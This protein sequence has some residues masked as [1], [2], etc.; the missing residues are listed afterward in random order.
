MNPMVFLI[1][2]CAVLLLGLLHVFFGYKLAR[3]LLPLCG[4]LLAVSALYIFVYDMLSLDTVQT[5]VF[6][7]GCSA[8]VYI[9]LFFIPRIAAFF[10]GLL[11]SALFIIFA[12]YAFNLHGFV[13]LY[14]AA[15]TAC[16][17]CGLLAA[18]YKRA[19]VIIAAALFGSCVSSFVG[20]Y[21]YIEGGN[22]LNFE[23]AGNILVPLEY[24][25]SE[26]V[27]LIGSAALALVLLGLAAQ[28]ARTADR[29]LLEGRLLTGKRGR[30]NKNN[31]AL[32]I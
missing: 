13:M 29:Q 18:V 19:G 8:A 31:M 27:L 15:M 21:L 10:T 17:L 9:I 3:F 12:V 11:G 32:D 22:V 5:Y 23:A 4:T 28:F 7:I 25:L 30:H 6:F 1:V 24:F 14:P 2:N 16:V 20:V 26:N